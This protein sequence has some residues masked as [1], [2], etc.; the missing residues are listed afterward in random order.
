MNYQSLSGYFRFGNSNKIYNLYDA[1]NYMWG[2]AMRAS[3]FSYGEVKFGSNMNEIFR[4]GDSPA[5][6]RAIKAG[7][8][9]R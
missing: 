4:G 5:D 3:G 8:N 6:Q 9:F 1:G 2:A 7:F